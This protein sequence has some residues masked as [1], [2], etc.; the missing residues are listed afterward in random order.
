LARAPISRPPLDPIARS[1]ASSLE[2]WL[3]LRRRRALDP[4]PLVGAGIV[5]DALAGRGPTHRR[6]GLAGGGGNALDSVQIV[7]VTTVFEIVS[8]LKSYSFLDRAQV[9]IGAAS[10]LPDHAHQIG[11]IAIMRHIGDIRIPAYGSS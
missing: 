11:D 4:A 9:D 8:A 3:R 5:C 1:D 2:E 10:K 7:E 6:S